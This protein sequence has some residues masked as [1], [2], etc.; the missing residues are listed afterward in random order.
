MR[1][2]LSHFAVGQIAGCLTLAVL[3]GIAA[4]GPKG[5]PT[6]AEAR[7]LFERKLRGPLD[8]GEM[9]IKTFS[10]TGGSNLPDGRYN[11]DY[12]ADVECLKNLEGGVMNAV[13]GVEARAGYISFQYD[14]N[15]GTQFI[16]TYAFQKAVPHAALTFRKSSG[17]WQGEE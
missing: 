11:I 1:N 10:A 16:C 7:Q 13:I 3:I 12:H 14:K 15:Q 9:R 6:E 4:C 5:P 17:S 8:R 2:L